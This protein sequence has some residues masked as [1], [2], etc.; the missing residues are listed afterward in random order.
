MLLYLTK[1]AEQPNSMSF[2]FQGRSERLV[3]HLLIGVATGVAIGVGGGIEASVRYQEAGSPG[4]S[5]GYGLHVAVTYALSIGVGMGM[6]GGLVRWLGLPTEKTAVASPLSTLRAARA[7]TLVCMVVPPSA[8]VIAIVCLNAGGF[9]TPGAIVGNVLY[10]ATALTG[11][12]LGIAI[13]AVFATALTAYPAYALITSWHMLVSRGGPRL[14]TLMNQ[15]RERDLLRREGA[16][17]QFRHAA[18]QEYL[19]DPGD[20]LD[21]N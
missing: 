21:Q 13:G 16:V 4:S 7:A 8:A 2:S 18:I 14:M 3:I 15:A 19:A 11:A 17:Y 9:A 5:T 20:G 12:G 6:V 1:P 10:P